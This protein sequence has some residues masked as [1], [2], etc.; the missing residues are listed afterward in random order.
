MR[1][2]TVTGA[3]TP[4]PKRALH[5]PHGDARVVVK[6][7]DEL[8]VRTSDSVG[9]HTGATARDVSAVRE[10]A[11]RHGLQFTPL[12]RI[13][14]HRVDALLARAEARSGRAQPDLLGL[15]VVTTADGSRPDLHVA[16]ELQ[17][18]AEVEYVAYE[19]TDVPPPVD[20][21]PATPS[22]TDG[23][24]YLGPA[25]GIDA[26]GAWAM[27]YD[28]TGVRIADVEASW[29]LAHEDLA[30]GQ[31]TTE[32]GQTPDENALMHIEHGTAV[33]GIVVGGDNG[34]GVTGI[35]NGS[36]LALYSES[37][38][39]GGWRRTEAILSAAADSAVGDVLMLEIQVTDP[40]VGEYVPGEVEES[41]WM[42]TRVAADA[43]VVVVAAA[44]NGSVDLDRPE[45]AYYRNRG[46]SG[47]IIVGAGDPQTHQVLGFSTFGLRV[48]V[49]GWGIEVFTTGYGNFAMYGDDPNQSYT[50]TFAGT[51]SATPFVAG[52]AAVVQQAVKDAE[53]EPLTSE[54]MRAVLRVTG[55]PQAGPGGH[56]GPLPQIPAAIA[57]ALS[58]HDEPPV[59]EITTPVATQTEDDM[60]ST[61]VEIMAS[62]DTA[63][64]EL[65]INGQVQPLVDAIPPFGF[66]AVDFPEG[67]WE[68]VAVATNV[69]GVVGESEPVVLEVGYVPPVTTSG[70]SESTTE[71]EQEDTSSSGGEVDDTTGE[72]PDDEDDTSTGDP[73]ATGGD[74]G[75]CGCT[76]SPRSGSAWLLVLLGAARRRRRHGM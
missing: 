42:A 35:A 27:G 59:V 34:Y 51:S 11:A 37:T 47:A 60:F 22:H 12:V 49:Q 50:A 72:P 54:Q 76:S 23:Q 48:D 31:M 13:D 61:S 62:P 45:L 57:T 4:L 55:V 44:G 38:V 19:S 64:V 30:D 18:L 56:I 17:A 3:R 43:G 58:P 75:G 26:M 66:D 8:R 70:G 1:G 21:D 53:L 67:T 46:D 68:L 7:V 9:L 36:T 63:S 32:P 69:W 29:Q 6:F 10:L 24:G 15:F 2:G 14:E 33:A 73:Q 65:S 41:V 40:I 71:P 16:R 5:V 74:D 39:E 20:L 52:A 25:P 28:G